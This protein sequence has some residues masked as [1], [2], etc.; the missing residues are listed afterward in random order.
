MEQQQQDEQQDVIRIQNEIQKDLISLI[1]PLLESDAAK[2]QLTILSESKESW[3]FYQGILDMIVQDTGCLHDLYNDIYWELIHCLVKSINIY[4]TKWDI[5]N[6]HLIDST[7]TIVLK[8]ME[9]LSNNSSAREFLLVIEEFH[10]SSFISLSTFTKISLISLSKNAL[11]RISVEKRFN[12][13]KCLIPPMIRILIDDEKKQQQQEELNAQQEKQRKRNDDQEDDEDE[14]DDQDEEEEQDDKSIQIVGPEKEETLSQQNS[15]QELCWQYPLSS[16]LDFIHS[17]IMDVKTLEKSVEQ[18]HSQELDATAIQQQQHLLLNALFKILSLEIVSLP[19]QPLLLNGNPLICMIGEC[20]SLLGVSNNYI[21][22]TDQRF[23][24]KKREME[25]EDLYFDEGLDEDDFEDDKDLHFDPINIKKDQEEEEE[26]EEEEEGEFPEEDQDN[27]I[28]RQHDL[29]LSYTGIGYYLYLLVLKP[30]EQYRLPSIQSPNS[31]LLSNLPYLIRL[32]QHKSYKIGFKAIQLV[33]FLSKRIKESSVQVDK[34]YLFN[35][36]ID[37]PVELVLGKQ[38]QEQNT[39]TTSE[40][41]KWINEQASALL[42]PQYHLLQL[43]QCII[44]FLVKCP[45][46]KIRTFTY[47]SFIV[48]LDCLCP[49]A[50]FNV[51]CN[52]IGTCIFPSFTGLLVHI[53]KEQINKAWLST[54]AEYRSYFVSPKILE[55]VQIPMQSGGNLMER[56]DAIMNGINMYRYLLIR[57]KETNNTGVWSKSKIMGARE[58]SLHPL[59]KNLLAT[60]K[61]FKASSQGDEAAMQKVLKG[62]SKMG[63]SDQLSTQDIQKASTLV[64][65][66]IDLALDVIDRIIELQDTLT[67]DD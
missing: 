65:H 30:T 58:Q 4:S 59:Q 26:E 47:N 56:M 53:F 33:S 63:M 35:P 37:D 16:V 45:V 62:V 15:D 12:F 34:K 36:V 44:S 21:L 13:L 49:S 29:D 52:L 14:E 3:V 2:Q 42:D 66:H 40:G 67:R 1:E 41:Q 28:E 48:L 8:I 60:Q 11:K 5:H 27:T 17:F 64:V 20:L 57:D 9:W 24:A 50:R 22:K 61:E 39:L 55:V 38:L 31:I 23:R 10:G 32:L 19:P 46:Q 6:P 7:C 51:L 54:D 43:I 25:L 18:Q